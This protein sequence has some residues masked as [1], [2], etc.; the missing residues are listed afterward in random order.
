VVSSVLEVIR[1]S[2]EVTGRMLPTFCLH[3]FLIIM[4]SKIYAFIRFYSVLEVL[5]TS[6]YSS[7]YVGKPY[8]FY[9]LKVYNFLS[10]IAKKK[11]YLLVV[12]EVVSF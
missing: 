1:A 12:S 2:L 6:S 4:S 10:E 11:N 8:V 5:A 9:L 7:V 3:R